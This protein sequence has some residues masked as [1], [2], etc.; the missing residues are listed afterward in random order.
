MK[1]IM[2]SGVN[3]LAVPRDWG[4]HLGV[5]TKRIKLERQEAAAGEG[6]LRL[7]QR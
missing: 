4:N 3:R 6:N 2:H 5:R 1:V 7:F